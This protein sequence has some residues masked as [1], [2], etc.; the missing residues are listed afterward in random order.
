M[1]LGML[2]P[3]V[4]WIC[5]VALAVWAVTASLPL[6]VLPPLGGE[7]NS[8]QHSQARQTNKAENQP[9]D[10]SLTPLIVL[11]GEN[12]VETNWG[13]P[14]CKNPQNHDEADLCQQIRIANVAEYTLA[15]GIL[16]L[17]GLALTVYYARKAAF[18]AV[19]AAQYGRTAA[20]AST[21]AADAEASEISKGLSFL[22]F[23]GEIA[24]LDVLGAEH[25]TCF[26]WRYN[27]AQNTFEQYDKEANKRT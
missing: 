18:A 3:I 23:Y 8:K 12:P 4:Y 9:A 13:K 19:E 15:V 27:G 21:T 24:S 6:D 7:N 16:T 11:Q 10:Q 1:P 5:F 17:I 2:V 26:C 25:K 20:I 22:W 14:N